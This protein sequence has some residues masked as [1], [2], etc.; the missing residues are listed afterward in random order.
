MSTLFIYNTKA[1]RKFS[2]SIVDDIKRSLPLDYAHHFIDITILDDFD[3]RD[4]ETLVAIGGDGTVNSVATIAQKH[5]KIM[6]IIPQGS[7]DGLARFLHI[8]RNVEEALNVIVGGNI[9]RID[10][11]FV[12][13]RLFTNVAGCGFEAKV[14]HRF[15]KA[16]Q[17]GLKGYIDI[18]RELYRKH[19]D[20]EILLTLDGKKV[21]IKCFSL[22]IANGAQWGNNF[23]IAS[24]ADIQD[25]VL[26]IAA[27]RKPRPI[28]I[29]LLLAYLLRKKQNDT[30]L[31]TYHKASA[32]D[33]KYSG[34]R[35]HID[36]EPLKL[37][38]KKKIRI[39][40]RGLAILMP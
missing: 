7:G 39:E 8:P 22:S 13:N 18:V 29:P 26:E 5:N 35:W 38:N 40:H 34:K 28:E 21:K 25:G 36:G 20:R 30:R 4:Y 3:V 1:G 19:N 37:R 2:E 15:N 9:D 14:A 17:R 6:G 11:G 33:V 27:M 31:I 16:S 12:G 10:V 23:E 32:I 24:K